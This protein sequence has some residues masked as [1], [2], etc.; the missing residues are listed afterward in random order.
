MPET[1]L[2]VMLTTK[3]AAEYMG[4]SERTVTAL[5]KRKAFKKTKVGRC[6]RWRRSELD[7]YLD[8]QTRAA[9]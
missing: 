9:R 1:K 8:K 4:C 3:Q 2:P 6:T 7:A 5:H